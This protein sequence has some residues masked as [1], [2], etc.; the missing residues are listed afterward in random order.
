MTVE[1]FAVLL[2]AFLAFGGLVCLLI[3]LWPER[4]D[5]TDDG[6]GCGTSRFGHFESVD[7]VRRPK[8]PA[9]STG[10]PERWGRPGD[11]A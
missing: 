7:R 11:A 1:P 9:R 5:R 6:L 10:S 4:G 2:T 3:A 8:L